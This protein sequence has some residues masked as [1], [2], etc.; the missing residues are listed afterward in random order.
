MPLNTLDLTAL[1][2]KELQAVAKEH[3][4]KANAKSEDIIDALAAAMNEESEED[5]EEITMSEDMQA[6]FYKLQLEFPEF[7]AA[8]NEDTAYYSQCYLWE[9]LEGVFLEE[10]GGDVAKISAT[11]RERLAAVDKLQ[12]EFPAVY[13]GYL[14]EFLEEDG[15][16]A[17]KVAAMLR[18]KMGNP[19][20]AKIVANKHVGYDNIPY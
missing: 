11:L 7:P 9:C 1:N 6:A 14:F 10:C 20:F 12:L 3:G 15:G 18:E 13:R 5:D 4:I 19:R 17:S 8:Y 2:R 16:D